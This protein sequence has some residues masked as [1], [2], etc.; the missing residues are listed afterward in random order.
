M[1][2]FVSFV[3]GVIAVLLVSFRALAAPAGWQQI[4]PGGDTLCAR[5]GEYSFLVRNGDPQKILVSFAGGGACWDDMTCDEGGPFTDTAERTFT[6]VEK[7]QGVYNFKDPRNPYR[8]WTHIFVPYCTGDVHVGQGDNTYTHMDNTPFVVHH[9]GG[10]NVKSVLQWLQAHYKS[11]AELGV[12]GCSAGSY[13][14]IL[15]TPALAELYPQAKINQLGDSGAGVTDSLFFPQWHLE[16]SFPA[17]IPSLDPSRVDWK[18]LTI[19]DIYNEIAKHYP[20]ARFSQFNHLKD[21][22]QIMYYAALGGNGLDWTQ[23]MYSNMVSVATVSPNFH[24]FV[25]PGDQHCATTTSHLY[26]TQTDGVSLDQWIRQGI[27]G[28][29]VENVKCKE[30]KIR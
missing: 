25:A 2:H 12:N 6:Q 24:F 3:V 20:Q 28:Q 17:W 22:V 10:I 19:V 23:R 26:N 27:S 29:N 16:P 21:R 4:K 8:D 30:C 18:K 9:R 1:K 11:P 14:S 7:G 13:G 5:G 15:W